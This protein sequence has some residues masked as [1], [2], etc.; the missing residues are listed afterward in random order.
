MS[1]LPYLQV[2]TAE[3]AVLVNLLHNVSI[4][5]A[6]ETRNP[7]REWIGALIRADVFG[8]VFPGR[9]RMAARLVYS[10]ASL[11]HRCNGIYAAMWAAA[12]V[13]YGP[14]A[15]GGLRLRMVL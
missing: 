14:V 6:A 10:A 12:V 13:S 15:R 4:A 11:S 9:P 3:R 1:F 8:W 2:F 5:S 7:Y